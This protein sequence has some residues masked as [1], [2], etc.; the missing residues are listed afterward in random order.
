M[1]SITT[2]SGKGSALTHAEMDA[3]FT[4]LNSDKPE[5][6]DGGTSTS[7]VLSASKILTLL[8]GKMDTGD[9]LFNHK[10]DWTTSTSYQLRDLVANSGGTYYCKSSH[11]SSASNEPGVGGSWES[12]WIL[13]AA[14]GDT[15]PSGDGTGDMLASTYDPTAV[16]GDAFDMDNMVEGATTKILTDTERTKLSNIE[17]NADVTDTANVTAAG[18]VMDSEVTDLA[19]IKSLDTTD[20]LFADVGDDLTAGYTSDS[21]SHGTISS[22]TVTPAPATGE[23]NFQH[24]TNGG[25]FTLAPPAN[26]CTVVLEITNNA[27]A[28]AVTTSG[29]TQ[30]TGDEFTTTNGDDFMCFITKTQ[31]FSLLNV[32]ALQ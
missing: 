23:E 3:N 8:S 27:S 31:N 32:V 6:N 19:G 26:P 29:F 24:L 11:T 15:G 21:Y 30:V 12:V 4:N 17:D 10:G 9:T 14:K 18:A 2:R 5:I 22:G 16:S 7:V 25:A 20:I 28:G 1:T 13:L